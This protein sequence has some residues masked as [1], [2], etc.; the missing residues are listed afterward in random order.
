LSPEQQ[1]RPQNIVMRVNV[2]RGGLISGEGNSVDFFAMTRDMTRTRR[3]SLAG[4]CR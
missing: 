3:V 1:I 4:R 2:P